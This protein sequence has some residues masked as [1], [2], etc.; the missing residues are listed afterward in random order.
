[1]FGDI[2]PPTLAH[3]DS[4]PR[5]I[6][7]YIGEGFEGIQHYKYR[8][9]SQEAQRSASLLYTAVLGTSLAARIDRIY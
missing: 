8:D 3:G 7:S 5:K 9:T 1:M 2:R 6:P 4:I